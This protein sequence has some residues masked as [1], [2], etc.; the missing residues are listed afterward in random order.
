MRTLVGLVA[1]AVAAIAVGFAWPRQHAGE[2]PAHFLGGVIRLLAANRYDEAWASLS[3]NDKAL[4]PR[5]VYVAC[6][7]RSPIPGHLTSLHVLGVGHDRIGVAVTFA[8]RIAGG[9]SLPTVRVVLTAHAVR[10]GH[11]WAWVFPPARRAVYRNGCGLPG[12]PPA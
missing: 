1:A 5:S 10:A 4:A 8:L 7:S 9:A 12:S 2:T 11:R 6:E 3:P